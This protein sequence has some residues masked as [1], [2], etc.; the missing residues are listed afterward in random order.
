MKKDTTN[1]FWV[2]RNEDGR[3]FMYNA[4]PIRI[5]NEFSPEYPGVAVWGLSKFDFP[6]VTWEN[7][8]KQVKVTLLGK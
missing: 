7:S 8:P 1:H 2:A 6:S 3:L 5:D 4:K